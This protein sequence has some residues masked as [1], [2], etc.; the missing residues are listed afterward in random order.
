MITNEFFSNEEILLFL[1]SNDTNIFLYDH[2]Y[3]RGISSVIDYAISAKKP[4]VISDSYMFRHIYSDNICV[5][6]TNIHEAIINSKNILDS[7]LNKYSNE[8]LINKIDS[9]IDKFN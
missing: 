3:G 1:S 8:N 2:M 4:F 7:L 5:Y 9:I 6:K